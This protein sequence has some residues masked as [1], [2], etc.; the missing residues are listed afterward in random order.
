MPYLLQFP[1]LK[2]KVGRKGTTYAVNKKKK[3]IKEI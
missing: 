2:H 3:K 1:D